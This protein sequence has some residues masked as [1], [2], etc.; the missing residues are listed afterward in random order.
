MFFERK[1]FFDN[2]RRAFYKR[3]RFFIA[4]IVGFDG[5]SLHHVKNAKAPR[6][7]RLLMLPPVVSIFWKPGGIFP[8][9]R[10]LRIF[11]YLGEGEGFYGF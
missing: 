9:S 11:P 1:I 8:P 2:L 3:G 7:E 10:S 4:V 5:L 6:P